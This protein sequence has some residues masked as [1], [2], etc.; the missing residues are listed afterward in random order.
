MAPQRSYA[1]AAS[2]AGPLPDAMHIGVD[3]PTRS[4]RTAADATGSELLLL[5]GEGHRVGEDGART[6]RFARLE[7]FGREPWAVESVS[8]RWSSQDYR[9]GDGIPYVS[10]GRRAAPG[11]YRGAGRW[12]AHARRS[13]A[14]ST[15]RTRSRSFSSL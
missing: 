10:R 8:Y 11:G 1:I 2:A 3:E 4:F 9:P 6:D 13:P 15:T 7:A 5:G 12:T 14:R